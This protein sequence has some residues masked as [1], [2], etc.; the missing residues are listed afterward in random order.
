MSENKK[1]LIMGV[2][3]SGTTSLYALLQKILEGV[4]PGNIDYVY[5]PFLWDRNAL[6][7]PYENI[8]EWG[9]VESISVDGCFYNKSIPFFCS[10]AESIDERSRQFLKEL[11]IASDDKAI[12]LNKM[13]RANGRVD[14]IRELAPDTKI[15]F[16][17]RNPVD[18]INSSIN[19]FSFFGGDFYK[20]DFDDFIH[21]VKSVFSKDLIEF[22]RF[23]EEQKEF[24]YWYY[25]NLSFLRAYEGNKNNIY[26][27]V[28]DEYLENRAGAISDLCD[29]LGVDFDESYVRESEKKVGPS[30]SSSNLTSSGFD[31]IFNKLDL[32]DG[33]LSKV[34]SNFS[35]EKI[36]VIKAKYCSRGFS[37][38]IDFSDRG[39]NSLEARKL[40]KQKKLELAKMTELEG[41]NQSL[42]YNHNKLI[43]FHEE[44]KKSYE[45]LK[46][47][48]EG[49]RSYSTEIDKFILK[50]QTTSFLKKPREKYKAYLALINKLKNKKA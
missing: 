29:F 45:E 5:E 37:N 3:R 28:Y 9:R 15:I 23:S 21:E 44:L 17:I 32:Y 39:G 12:V 47:S 31:Y 22:D 41:Y 7:K 26:P 4:A 35:A 20:S 48:Y 19:M 36:Q 33:L 2:G 38:E 10:E 25:M 14:L 8:E 18:S 1:I 46:T 13:I 27:I 40:L 6:N 11:L 34:G 30:H 42:K 16:M 49:L 43:G 50:L 24:L